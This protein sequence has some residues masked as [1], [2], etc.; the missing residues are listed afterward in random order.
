MGYLDGEA[1]LDVAMRAAKDAC[2]LHYH[3]STP[4]EEVPAGPWSRVRD[5]AKRAGFAAELL[6]VNRIKSYAPRIQH[7]VLDVRLRRLG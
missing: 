3:E 4:A 5:A 6:A 2:V 7:V 1:Y